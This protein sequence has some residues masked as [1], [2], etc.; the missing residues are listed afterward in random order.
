MCGH[1]RDRDHGYLG[2][3]GWR[4]MYWPLPVSEGCRS[5]C[6]NTQATALGC[7]CCSS[8][9]WLVALS[10]HRSYRFFRLPVIALS[11]RTT[12]RKRSGCHAGVWRVEGCVKQDDVAMLCWREA[13]RTCVTRC[14]RYNRRRRGREAQESLMSCV[15]SMSNG[16]FVEAFHGCNSGATVSLVCCT[17]CPDIHHHFTSHNLKASPPIHQT[18]SR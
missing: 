12:V 15:E 14:I 4:N 9:S 10:W 17:P 1:V 2:C 3:H 6:L 8:W 11:D 16:D 18:Y 13:C 7:V 5:V